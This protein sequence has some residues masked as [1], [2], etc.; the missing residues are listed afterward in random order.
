[1]V[2]IDPGRVPS[3]A[4]VP[5]RVLASTAMSMITASIVVFARSWLC[6]LDNIAIDG[7]I[8][9]EQKGAMSEVSGWRSRDQ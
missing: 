7:F 8:I 9:R 3:D 2:S 6:K 1:M 5:P 4:F